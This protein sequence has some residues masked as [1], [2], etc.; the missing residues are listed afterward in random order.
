MDAYDMSWLAGRTLSGAELLG[1]GFWRF[2]FGDEIVLSVECPW[3]LIHI[4]KIVLSS[5]DHG[6]T[7]GKGMPVDCETGI[8]GYLIGLHVRW[9]EVRTET[10]DIVLGFET[11][12]RLEILPLSTGFESWRIVKPCGYEAVAQGGGAILVWEGRGNGAI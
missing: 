1:H 2:D 7:Y 10:R 5:Q 9:A 6:R 3:R 12:A 8:R 4:N 11:G